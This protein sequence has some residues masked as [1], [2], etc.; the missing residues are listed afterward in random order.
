MAQSNHSTSKPECGT[1]RAGTSMCNSIPATH[2]YFNRHLFTAV[3]VFMFLWHR[4]FV[5]TASAPGLLSCLIGTTNAQETEICEDQI[6]RNHYISLFATLFL[7]LVIFGAGK[8]WSY[9]SKIKNNYCNR[10]LQAEKWYRDHESHFQS[11]S[12]DFREASKSCD[13]WR[14]HHDADSI[15]GEKTLGNMLK[16][17]NKLGKKAIKEGK[18]VRKCRQEIEHLKNQR[19]TFLIMFSITATAA[20]VS[21]GSL[22]LSTIVFFMR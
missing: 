21:V 9:V 15:S 16:R 14:K 13:E 1:D 17:A 19:D 4:D 10:I 22:F 2:P 8:A 7:T 20:F 12:N 5:I 6:Y 11:F 18:V 3:A